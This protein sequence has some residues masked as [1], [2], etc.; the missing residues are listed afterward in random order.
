MKQGLIGVNVVGESGGG[1]MKKFARKVLLV[2][3]FHCHN[4]LF[5]LLQGSML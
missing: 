3:T 4:I 5:Y 2:A 1:A